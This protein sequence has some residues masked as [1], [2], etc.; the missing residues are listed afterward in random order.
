M[1]SEQFAGEGRWCR[2]E[3][4]AI[5]RV[6]ASPVTQGSLGGGRTRRSEG[7]RVSPRALPCQ[8]FIHL[9]FTCC[10]SGSQSLLG[11]SSLLFTRLLSAVGAASPDV[12]TSS[13]GG[14]ESPSSLVPGRTLCS[15]VFLWLPT[16]AAQS[17][18][19]ARW[20]GKKLFLPRPGCPAPTEMS[21]LQCL[22]RH[23]WEWPFPIALPAF[24]GRGSRPGVGE[25]G[26]HCQDTSEWPMGPGLQ[27]REAGAT[28]KAHGSV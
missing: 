19:L 10:S 5:S 3:R 27:V 15:Q 25:E 21:L 17:G 22:L 16:A 23:L 24:H 11:P 9:S 26:G 20:R 28:T 12:W 8:L 4:G 14:P 18:R 2:P 6:W 13:P 1:G 7:R